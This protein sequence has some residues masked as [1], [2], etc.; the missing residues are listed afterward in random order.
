[1]NSFT[2]GVLWNRLSTL[3]YK[4]GRTA[5]RP[6][7]L[8][9]YVMESKETPKKDKLLIFSALTYVVFPI[10]FL[11]AKRLPIIGWLDE[12]VSV[13]IAYQKI[14]KYITPQMEIKVDEVLDRWFP[15]YT[16]YEEL[17]M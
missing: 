1:M 14:C 12:I 10:D 17:P 7:L 4:A 9:Y 8:M 13:S 2:I 5:M 15:E 16:D 11:D 3:A 6:M